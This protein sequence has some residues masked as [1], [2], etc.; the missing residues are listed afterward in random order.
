MLARTLV[1]C[2]QNAQ[3]SQSN[4]FLRFCRCFRE[5][6]SG[7]D[8]P[9]PA[10]QVDIGLDSVAPDIAR[11]LD[12]LFGNADGIGTLSRAQTSV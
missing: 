9:I 5:L 3:A 1:H 2:V 10:W 11:W 4:Y 12:K 8:F 6:H 7:S